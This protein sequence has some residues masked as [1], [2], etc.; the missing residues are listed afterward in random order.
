MSIDT[1]RTRREARSKS[2]AALLVIGLLALALTVLVQAASGVTHAGWKPVIGK[3]VA[4]PLQPQAGKRFTVVFR[5]TRSDTGKP[6]TAGTMV[7]VPSV[8]AR[9]LAHT[10]SF[11]GGRARL[12]FIVPT[13]A[14]GKLVKVALTIK[15]GGGSATKVASYKVAT[16]PQ[17]LVSVSDASVVE[18]SAKTTPISFTLSLST[19]TTR[20]VTVRFATVDGTATAPSDYVAASGTVT[21]QPGTRVDRVTIDVVGDTA[22]EPDETF[23]LELSGAVG[24]TIARGTA[25]G[26]ITNDDTA[27]P[28]TS[29]EYKGI[30]QNGNFVFFTVLGNRTVTH[31]RVNDLPCTCDGPLRL[32]GGQNFGDSTLGIRPDGSFLGKGN[33]DGSDPSGDV[34]WTHW[35]VELTG[36]FTTATTV[37]GTIIEHYELN[38]E[39][40]HFRC[41]TGL[42]TWT[43]SFQG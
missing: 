18:G 38:Y 5:V 40:R 37:T 29:G 22:I 42:I 8:A 21:F 41:T 15:A 33:W 32:F 2:S 7:C 39:G 43:A 12:S 24:A 10:E 36:Q 35:D 23:G 11:R 6:V 9:A 30:T 4:A 17:P 27:V 20:A 34:E 25:T 3:P 13:N 19:A 16:A 26:T 14:A 31:F 1:Q 28:V